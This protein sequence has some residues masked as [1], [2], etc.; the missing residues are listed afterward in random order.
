MNDKKF[1][2]IIATLGE[3]Y[4][5][6]VTPLVARVYWQALKP[7]SDEEVEQALVAY[8]SD[9][10]VC[11]YWPQPGALIAKI[12]GTSKQLQLSV[13]SKAIEVWDLVYKKV[14]NG[15]PYESLE[16]DDR[17]AL[18]VISAMGGWAHLCRMRED[19]VTWK[20]K[21]FISNYLTLQGSENLPERLAGIGEK[22]H[23]KLEAKKSLDRIYNKSEV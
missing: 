1:K 10:D 6:T 22:S 23:E 19:E 12:T 3:Q 14:C 2:E 17:L 5:K 21:E 18:K 13:E 9:P 4:G 20:K 16:L 7:Y 11:Q 8:I 15:S